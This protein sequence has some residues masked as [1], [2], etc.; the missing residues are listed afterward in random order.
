M[1]HRDLKPANVLLT[2]EGE[3][4]VTDF[5]L[6]KRMQDDPNATEARYATQSGA[7]VGTPSYMAPEQAAGKG[8]LVGPLAD[9]YS[10]GAVLYDLLTGRPPFVAATV[11]ETL[12]QVATA[13]PPSPASLQPRLPR[14]VV[15]VCLK[16][17]RK[18][19]EKRYGTAG[20]FA[21][22]LRRFLDGEPIHAVRASRWERLV[23]W[24]RRRPAAA[25]LVAVT[26]IA[27]LALLGGGIAYQ[28]KLNRALAEAKADRQLAIARLVRM[29]V[30]SGM[31]LVDRGNVAQSLPFLIEALRVS[32]EINQDTSTPKEAVVADERMQRVRLA[33][34]LRECPRLLRTWSHDGQVSD[35]AFSPDGKRVVTAGTDNLA[36][37]WDVASWEP[38]GPPLRHEGDVNSACFSPDGTR[39]LTAS[40]DGPPASGTS[41]RD[42]KSAGPRFTRGVAEAAFSPD[43][44]RFCTAGADARPVWTP[45]RDRNCSHP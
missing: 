33:M 21:D 35:A 42:R 38:I 14:D 23:K 29:S 44:L 1:V 41:R 16:C 7:A 19:P 27:A 6:A 40:T 12:V 13:E 11:V 10:L 4:K 30:Q 34:I 36:R 25:A 20:E 8:K 43:G 22:D 17:L 45:P 5:G 3:P 9:V 26:T 2:A 32:T 31:D 18:E 37:V 28:V 15:T 39:V 24:V